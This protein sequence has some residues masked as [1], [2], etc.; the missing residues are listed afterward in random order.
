MTGNAAGIRLPGARPIAALDGLRGVAILLVIWHNVNLL[1]EPVAAIYRPF[2]TLAHIGWIGVQLFFVLSGFLI[3]GGLLDSSRAPNY[4]SSFFCRRILRIL[5]LYYAVLLLAL[6]L[7]P[8]LL[9]PPEALATTLHNQIWLWTFTLNWVQPFGTSVQGF[10]HF[11]SL[12][13]EEQFYLLWPLLLRRSTA[14]HALKLCVVVALASLAV[15]ATLMIAGASSQ[16]IYEFTVCR[17]DALAL[18][19]VA[20]A[21]VRLP[22]AMMLARMSRRLYLYAVILLVVTGLATRYFSTDDRAFQLVGYSFIAGAFALMVLAATVSSPQSPAAQPVSS[23]RLTRLLG[24]AALTSIGRYSY[25]MYIFHL[26]LHV[27]IGLPLL[28]RISHPITSAV[29]VTYVVALAA[30]CYVAAAISYHA[31]EKHFLRLKRHFAPMP[32]RALAL[33]AGSGRHSLDNA[34]P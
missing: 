12:A 18:G 22:V 13:V 14:P 16:A 31:F 19:G 10:S 1:V 7:A 34:Q 33:S 27:F 24:S 8:V 11:W 5:P 9:R 21:L 28:N 25:A 23:R 15:R 26:P 29:A 30:V 6:V 32:A 20:A 4:Y 3:T 17:M 2:V